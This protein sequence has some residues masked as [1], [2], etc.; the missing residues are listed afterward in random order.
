[1][2]LDGNLLVRD[3]QHQSALSAQQSRKTANLSGFALIT[4]ENPPPRALT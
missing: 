3:Q 4:A 2:I 1:M